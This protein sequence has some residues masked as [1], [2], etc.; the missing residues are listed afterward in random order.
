MY[1][2]IFEVHES[3]PQVLQI[4]LPEVLGLLRCPESSEAQ[5]NGTW[6]GLV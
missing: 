5:S 1:T 2:Y 6:A 4:F 3:V